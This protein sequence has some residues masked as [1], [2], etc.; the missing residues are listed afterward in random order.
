MH[1]ASAPAGA[2]A[3]AGAPLR[4]IEQLLGKPPQAAV[5]WWTHCIRATQPAACWHAVIA[6]VQ[7]VH[8]FG[9]HVH[10]SKFA[11]P[12]D[13]DPESPA[14]AGP[15]LDVEVD[16]VVD[17]LDVVDVDDVAGLVEDVG[18]DVVPVLAD[19]V[20]VS[21]PNEC[22]VVVDELFVSESDEESVTAAEP[23]PFAV[24]PGSAAQANAGSTPR[25]RTA[26]RRRNRVRV[27]CTMSLAS[28]PPRGCSSR[29]IA[30]N[31][32]PP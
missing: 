9:M 7:S 17:V 13:I 12:P 29:N 31:A 2:L 15:V 24:S 3:P 26:H 25:P 21:V 20:P 8:L 22:V 6:D 18:F 4:H 28:L 32:R 14:S 23:V 16:D 11:S 27:T 10:R 30:I 5:F 19:V 1:E